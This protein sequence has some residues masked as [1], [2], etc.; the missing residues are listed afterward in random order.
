MRALVFR[1]MRKCERIFCAD[2]RN[3]L[4]NWGGGLTKPWN[5]MEWLCLVKTDRLSLNPFTILDVK[6]IL[7]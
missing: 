6:S 2:L 4:R 3:A 5:V 7:R 1:E